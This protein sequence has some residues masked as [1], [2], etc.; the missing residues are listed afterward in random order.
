MKLLAIPFGVAGLPGLGLVRR[1]ITLALCAGSFWAGMQ[2]ERATAPGGAI[3]EG[4][5][6][7]AVH[8]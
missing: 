7:G 2:V 4:C 5:D 3:C 8:E 6:K 1:L